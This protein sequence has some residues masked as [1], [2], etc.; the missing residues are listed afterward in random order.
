MDESSEMETSC[1]L[2]RRSVGI[3]PTVTN[4]PL[5]LDVGYKVAEGVIKGTPSPSTF[6]MICD[7]DSKPT[8]S[9]MEFRKKQQSFEI[10]VRNISKF[11][12]CKLKF[13]I[14]FYRICRSKIVTKKN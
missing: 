14:R 5:N 2:R 6:K 1:G 12:L 3:D 4:I 11:L 8:S 9:L 10:H 7:D 13:L